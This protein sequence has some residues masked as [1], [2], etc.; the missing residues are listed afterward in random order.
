MVAIITSKFNNSPIQRPI[1]LNPKFGIPATFAVFNST[2]RYSDII[3][4]QYYPHTYSAWSERST[5]YGQGYNF[6]AQDQSQWFSA[7]SYGYAFTVFIS[8]VPHQ[9]ENAS[10]SFASV[11][12]NYGGQSKGINSSSDGGYK[13]TGGSVGTGQL[14]LNKIHT[15]AM[16]CTGSNG[17]I[18]AYIDGRFL[19]SD[20]GTI[21]SYDQRGQANVYAGTG[22]DK[23]LL[24]FGYWKEVL[25]NSA[26]AEI[27]ENPW[28]TVKD[29]GKLA[30]THVP[31]TIK[32]ARPTLDLSRTAS[33]VRN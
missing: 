3:S 26:L 23:T 14:I 4:G 6:Y 9:L 13:V 31:P 24:L 33:I 17:T 25:P 32:I 30:L 28:V 2:T 5:A 29:R 22:M 15:I 10:Y 1:Y 11:A 19:C 12:S 21:G 7:K 8:F 27:T 18:N 16:S 20:T